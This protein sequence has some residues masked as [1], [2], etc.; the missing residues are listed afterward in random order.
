M[1]SWLITI[2]NLNT[3]RFH[4]ETFSQTHKAFEMIYLRIRWIPNAQSQLPAIHTE[5]MTVYSFWRIEKD[6]S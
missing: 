5:T 6:K 3:C 4:L 2:H 1:Y